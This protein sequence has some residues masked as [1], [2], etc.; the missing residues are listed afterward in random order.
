[1]KFAVT[2]KPSAEADLAAIWVASSDRD[3]ISKEADELVAALSRN[4]LFEGESRAGSGRIVVVRPL[5]AQFEVREDHRI[6][7]VLAF[8]GPRIAA[9]RI[10]G[11]TVRAP[12]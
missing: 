12:H 11:S 5:V 6:V 7:E 9:E 2:W 1:M 8:G 3:A 10:G 4:P